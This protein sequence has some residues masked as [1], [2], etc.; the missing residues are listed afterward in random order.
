MIRVAGWN[1]EE[2]RHFRAADYHNALSK[3][4]LEQA[5]Q[6]PEKSHLHRQAAVSHK[7][8]ADAHHR[9]AGRAS[10]T[11][12]YSQTSFEA[13]GTADAR[14]ASKKA[15]ASEKDSARLRKGIPDPA[16]LG[17]TADK[18]WEHRLAAS[19]HSQA[20]LDHRRLGNDAEAEL[21]DVAAGRHSHMAGLKARQEEKDKLAESSY[22]PE[23]PGGGKPDGE[24][25][26]SMS[27][28]AHKASIAAH[29]NT[30]SY[31]GKQYLK[32]EFLNDSSEALHHAV[33]GHSEKAAKHHHQMSS[34]HETMANFIDNNEDQE[35][36][37]RKAMKLHDQAA[38]YHEKR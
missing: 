7:L 29:A 19:Y 35:M 23:K 14:K 25:G 24:A 31:T 38:A 36:L 21:H 20:A 30:T 9:V 22:Y 32:H 33:A 16:F 2:G 37:H 8:A 18:Y 10:G 26:I 12:H 28:K 3:M 13:E 6:D 27:G 34:L 4:H 1:S 15:L 5:R 17:T 11:T